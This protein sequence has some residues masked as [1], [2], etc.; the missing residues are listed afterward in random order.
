MSSKTPDTIQA[1]RRR[2]AF[3]LPLIACG[4]AVPAVQARTG[5]HQASRTLM[6]TRVDLTL[7][8]KD[9]A[10]LA[11]AAEAALAEMARLEDMMSRY[12]NTS[13]LNAINLAAGIQPVTVPPELLQVLLMAQLASQASGGD[14]DATV[15]SLRGWNFSSNGNSIP[16]AQQIAA[17]LPLVNQKHLIID[18]R[19]STAYLS[20]RGT[21]LDLGGIAKLPIL[22]AGMRRL[23]GMGVNN[24][25]LN[26]GGDVLVNG[27]L[28]GR[29]WRVGLRDPRQP[30]K[31][32]G[33]LALNRGFV[34]A[35]GDYERFVMR[36]GK[37]LHH[38][39]DP[40]TGYPTH[41]PHGVTLIGDDLAAIN[42]LGTAI[43]VAGAA[44]GRARVAHLAGVDAMIVDADGEL[45][46][47]P[48]MEQSLQKV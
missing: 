27:Q 5:I 1:G 46:L 23:Q 24:A 35:S 34:A 11:A 28:N 14:F 9:T 41:G 42:G 2:L 6:G 36:D 20:K 13:A 32:L 33:V 48:G 21:R 8:G 31:L 19:H 4:L 15:G 3:A 37:R 44:A 29:P 39:I 22:E 16:S 30:G 45:W 7:Q 38:I 25:M 10:Q 43:M 47:S 40:K 26:G 12:N 17:Q 18:Q